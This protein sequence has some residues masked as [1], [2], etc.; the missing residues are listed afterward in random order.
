MR[1]IILAAGRGSRMGNLTALQPKGLVTLAGQTLLERQCH[2]LNAHGFDQIAI[3][4]GYQPEAF[5]LKHVTYFDNPDWQQTNMVMSL[6]AAKTW[7]EQDTCVV[8]Y[9]D[10][11]YG[12]A[13]LQPLSSHSGDIVLPYNRNWLHLWQNRF[14]DPLSDAESFRVDATGHLLEIGNKCQSLSEIQGQYM[15]LLRFTPTGWQTVWQVLNQFTPESQ[16][17]LDMTSLLQLLL[18]QG[19]AIDTF[20]SD[21]LWLEIDSQPD[22]QLYEH[23]LAQGLLTLE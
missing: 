9:A 6:C 23:W 16:N 2:T 14:A 5:T 22:L 15:G 21:S 20:P 18:H 4:R 19:V 7:L 3:V 1:A 12:A 10:I 11:V 8:T 13:V 17:R